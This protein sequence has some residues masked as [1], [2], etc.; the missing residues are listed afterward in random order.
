MPAAIRKYRITICLIAIL[1]LSFW[2][3]DLTGQTFNNN[4]RTIYLMRAKEFYGSGVKM[5]L[6]I[7]GELFHK[8]KNGS[9]LIIKTNTMDTLNIQI[10]YPPLK[11]YKSEV[12]QIL[13]ENGSDVYVDLF[14]WGERYNPLKHSGVLIGPTGGTPEFNIEIVEMDKNEGKQKFND[15]L[16][17]KNNKKVN[18]KRY[19]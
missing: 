8:I 11:R 15:S 14:Y 16:S 19:P 17:F 1:L 13:P 5:N 10:V 7:N 4:D 12:L 2:Q 6:M 9:R 18:E 3:K